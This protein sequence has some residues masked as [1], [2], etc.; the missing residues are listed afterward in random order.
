VG[1]GPSTI[2]MCSTTEGKSVSLR[3]PS[4]SCPE[5]GAKRKRIRCLTVRRRKKASDSRKLSTKE[6]LP[7]KEKDWLPKIPIITRV[8]DFPF[9]SLILEKHPER[10]S[11]GKICVPSVKLP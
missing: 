6:A 2:T 1:I 9:A 10:S 4:I 7:E 11:S 3:G 8:R 5:T